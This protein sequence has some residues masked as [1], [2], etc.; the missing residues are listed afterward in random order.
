MPSL[1][2][3]WLPAPNLSPTSTAHSHLLSQMLLAT[4]RVTWLPEERAD[5]RS[6]TVAP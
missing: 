2:S 5:T 4:T 1:R 3:S 6:S